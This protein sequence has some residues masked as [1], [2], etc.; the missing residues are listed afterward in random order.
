MTERVSKRRTRHI[1]LYL[2]ATENGML[3]ALMDALGM[4]RGEMLRYLIRTKWTEWCT[5]EDP[6]T[7]EPKWPAMPKSTS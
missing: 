1:S 4:T 7:K 6:R 5:S 2:S 3:G